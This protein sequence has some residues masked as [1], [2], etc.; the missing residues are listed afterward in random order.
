MAHRTMPRTGRR[1]LLVGGLVLALGTAMIA[2]LPAVPAAAA[3]PVG[4]VRLAHLSPD[5]PE[6]NVYLSKENDASFTPQVFHGVGYGVVSK[7]LALPVGTY[8]VGMKLASADQSGPATL[9]TQVTVAAG[10]AYTVAGTGKFANLG[11]TVLTDDLTAPGS[12]QAKVRIIQASVAAPVLDVA[13]ANG[14]PIASGV[15]FAT[16][17]PYEVVAPGQWTLRVQPTGSA[18]V[19]TLGASLSPGGVYSLLVLDGP[20][21]LRAQLRV[22]AKGPG[23]VPDGGIEAGLGGTG[24]SPATGVDPLVVVSGAVAVLA[25]L[26]AAALLLRRR[27]L[28]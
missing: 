13:M 7:Y 21:G 28:A 5:T 22:D 10:G 17:T 20:H 4:Y 9:S 1:D 8:A 15:G 3:A 14:T 23:R 2:L 6:V 27:R 19:T 25:A 18:A 24:T 11:L 12:N 26:L 16:T